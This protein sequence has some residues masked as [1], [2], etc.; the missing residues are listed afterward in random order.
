[1]ELQPNGFQQMAGMVCYYNSS[2]FHY[3]YVSIDEE[4]GRHIR[5]MSCLPD[6]VQSDVFSAPIPIPAQGSVR[7]RVEVDFE[8]LYFAFRIGGG[9]WQRLPGPLDASIL[10]DEAA[11]PGSANFTGSFVGVYCQD[12]AG[13]CTAADFDYFTYRGRGYHQDPFD[14]EEPTRADL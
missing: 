8:R 5:V 12:L 6:V 2:K 10:S 9:E 4:L 11:S 14:E 13:T 1:M 7:L 3:L